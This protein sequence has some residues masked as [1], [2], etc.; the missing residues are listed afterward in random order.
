MRERVLE[1]LGKYMS[2]LHAEMTLRRTADKVGVNPKL[3]DPSAFPRLAAALEVSLKL[4]AD[5]SEVD[6]AIGELREVLTPDSPI[7][8]KVELRSEADMSLARQAARNLAE[9]MGARSFTAQKFT[10]AVSELARNIVQY[11]GSGEIE[12]SPL[13]TSTSR[14]LKVLAV[15]Q[16]PGINNLDEILDGRYRSRTGLGKG[17]LGVRRL[18]D[19]FE[20]TSNDSGTRVEAELHL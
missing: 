17:I 5:E 3:T 7:S 4:F 2:R 18:M 19:R 12:L 16:G 15:D 11:A 8:V 13:T 1:V 20:I 14:G 6:G 9:K 10:T